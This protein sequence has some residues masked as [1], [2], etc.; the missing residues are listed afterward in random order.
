MGDNPIAIIALRARQ[1]AKG[2]R[3]KAKGKRQ[4]AKFDYNSFCCLYQYPSLNA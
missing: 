1:E 4:K 2:K 3:Q